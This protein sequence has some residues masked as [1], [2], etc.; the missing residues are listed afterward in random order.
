MSLND[1]DRTQSELLRNEPLPNNDDNG[2]W[3]CIHAEWD[4]YDGYYNC[5][6]SLNDELFGDFRASSSVQ[7]LISQFLL[8]N[9]LI[10]VQITDNGIGRY[11]KLFEFEEN[12]EDE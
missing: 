11:C 5:Y 4:D 2:C 6:H 12:Q 8:D 3:N 9:D 7:G 1:L 10:D